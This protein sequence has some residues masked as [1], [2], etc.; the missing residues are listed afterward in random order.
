MCAAPAAPV[1]L[2]T[3]APALAP[4]LKF[5]FDHMMHQC[6]IGTIILIRDQLFFYVP[7]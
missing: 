7:L 1:A 6:F 3:L 4:G 2:G 5:W